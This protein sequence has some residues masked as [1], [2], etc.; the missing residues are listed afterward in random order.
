[1]KPLG[2][3]SGQTQV[4]FLKIAK[5]PEFWVF[6][7]LITHH[8][9]FLSK[10]CYFSKVQSIGNLWWKFIQFDRDLRPGRKGSF[11]LTRL[12]IYKWLAL[13]SNF[14]WD[15]L[16]D[17]LKTKCWWTRPN[18]LQNDCSHKVRIIALK[19]AY[20]SKNRVYGNLIYSI[21]QRW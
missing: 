14:V 5:T 21:K 6:G 10:L 20:Y 4:A 17:V 18:H 8:F 9:G 2:Q 3:V 12:Y 15:G 19:K 13:L 7:D 1:M 11:F 16:R